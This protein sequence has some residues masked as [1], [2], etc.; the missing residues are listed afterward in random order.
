MLEFKQLINALPGSFLMLTKEGLII[1]LSKDCLKLLNKEA[2][3]LIGKSVFEILS[4]NDQENNL[5]HT[6]L[7][8]AATTKQS[9]TILASHQQ[10]NNSSPEKFKLECRPVL[11]EQEETTYILLYIELI[12]ASGQTTPKCTQLLNCTAD[13][14]I[15][16]NENGIIE[17]INKEAESVFGYEP[18]EINGKL[19]EELIPSGSRKKHIGYRKDFVDDKKKRFMHSGLALSG[20]RKNGTTFPADIALIPAY[21]DEGSFIVVTVRDITEKTNEKKKLED[22]THQLQLHNEQLEEKVRVRTEEIA[23]RELQYRYLFE[24]NPMPMWIF[25][26]ETLQFLDVNQMALQTYGYNR[27]EFLS[28]TIMDI[29]PDEEKKRFLEVE[30]ATHFHPENR[31]NIWRH[32]KKDGTLMQVEVIGQPIEFNRKK[33]RLVLITDVT[34][35]IKSE[36][37]LIESENRF[38]ALIENSYDI[39]NLLDAEFKIIY[40]SPSAVRITGRTDEET[41]GQTSLSNIHPDDRQSITEGIKRLMQSPGNTEKTLFRYMAKNGTYIWME[42]LATNLLH[43]EYVKAIIFNYRDVTERILAEEKF[44]Q[45]EE[46]YRNTLDNMIEGVQIIGFD[47]KYI[48]VNEAFAKQAGHKK[49]DLIGKHIMEVIPEMKGNRIYEIAEHCLEKNTPLQ[50][51]NRFILPDSTEKWFQLSIQ[52]TTYGIF[53]LSVDITEKVK[54]TQALKEEKNKLDQ[55][56]AASPGVI[57]SFHMDVNNNFTLYYANSASENIYGLSY[58]TLKENFE[59]FVDMIDVDDRENVLNAVYDSANKLSKLQLEYKYNH[60]VKGPVWHEV[61][62]I[63]VKEPDGSITWHGVVID[64]TERRKSEENLAAQNARLQNLSNNLPGLMIFQLAGKSWEERKFTYISDEVERITGHTPAEVMKDPMIIYS[65]IHEEDVPNLIKE[66]EKTAKLLTV[67]N[68][69]VRFRN[70]NNEIR[71]L[72]I[73]STPRKQHDGMI[74]WDGFHIDI[75]E[76]KNSENE[77][78]ISNERYKAVAKATSDAIWDF[79]FK[80]RRGFILGTGYKYLFGYPI[81]NDYAEE[82]FWEDKLHPDE[83]EKVIREMNA[84]LANK[85]KVKGSAE[86]RFRKADGSYAVVREMF[87]I[88][89]DKEGNPLKLLGSKHDITSRKIADDEL[90]KRYQENRLLK[91]R[92]SAILNTLPADIALIDRKGII[93]DSNDE[94]KHVK[95]KTNFLIYGYKKGDCYL[96]VSPTTEIADKKN[97]QKAIKGIRSVLSGRSKEF[98][99]EYCCSSVKSKK[100]F[101]MITTQLKGKGFLGAVVM[102]IDITEIKRLEDERLKSKTEEQRK[103]TEAMVQGQEKERNAIGIELH[104]NVNQ[105]LV[106]SNMLLSMI[107]A[108]PAL[109]NEL[110][111]KCIENIRFAVN[112]NRRI[113]HELVIPNRVTETLLQ[114]VRR[115]AK[116]MFNDTGIKT[117]IIQQ[118]FNEE[119]LTEEQKLTVYRIVQEQCTNILKHANAGSVVFRFSISNNLFRLRISDN[120]IGMKKEKI[121]EGIGLRNIRHRLTVVNG[122]ATID[123]AKGKGF[124]LIIEMP[125]THF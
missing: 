77:S 43:D 66:E 94:W 32:F 74:V 48:Y 35:K 59:Q 20:L 53:I 37:K 60:P 78:K 36:N 89:R 123:S 121:E 95:N 107:E 3:L 27:Q 21:T 80:T 39:I 117:K 56:A 58:E 14:I 26:A 23:L 93:Q 8:K 29:R 125:I 72:N 65:R 15:I 69:E 9:D 62:D 11:N 61:S 63:P 87:F 57:H 45:T 119:L 16:T 54:A 115:V 10:E 111:P 68:V 4:L 25:D 83:K 122:S 84:V 6:S 90:Q 42:G 91:E 102:H 86:Y 50:I 12:P 100:W 118:D 103:I 17:Y 114:Q 82:G 47:E 13:A 34:E 71:W 46:R 22:L 109:M 44:K 40:R 99:F 79:D 81:V 92:F 106:S 5:L 30:F 1:S 116:T 67:F 49:E 51:E 112:E 70:I 75:T 31:K 55:L 98:V 64:V 38:R 108:N 76:R 33:A 105:I 19:I 73:I 2:D 96:Q 124:T 104:D 113:A 24:N 97:A 41:I 110:L 28:M 101:R 52:P 88:I 85:H 120:G 7:K 18:D